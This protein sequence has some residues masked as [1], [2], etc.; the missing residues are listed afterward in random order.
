M[1]ITIFIRHIN[2]SISI[3]DTI[4][5]ILSFREFLYYSTKNH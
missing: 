4:N 5:F 2:P 3:V 1:T